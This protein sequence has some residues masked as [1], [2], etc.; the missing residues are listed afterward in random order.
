MKAILKSIHSATFEMHYEEIQPQEIFSFD[1]SVE[2]GANEIQGSEIFNFWAMSPM[3]LYQ[4]FCRQRNTTAVLAKDLIIA[5]QCNLDTITA[6]LSEYVNSIPEATMWEVLAKKFGKWGAWEF[7][8]Y[9]EFDKQLPKKEC[10][11]VLK[12]IFID[13]KLT[14]PLQSDIFEQAKS[15]PIFAQVNSLEMPQSEVILKMK[16]LLFKDLLLE[17][18]PIFGRGNIIVF[19]KDIKQVHLLLANYINSLQ[20]ISWEDVV[21][22]LE[23]IGKIVK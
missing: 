15:F 14:I 21:Y 8:D 12:N 13:S 16:I 17:K 7:E 10:K 19:Q 1:I 18:Q 9:V 6:F 20:E 3:F 23:R 22:K 2:L 4:Y 5:P 11:A